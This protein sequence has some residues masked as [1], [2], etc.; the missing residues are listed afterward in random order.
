MRSVAWIGF[1]LA[2]CA[3]QPVDL[4]FT[5]DFDGVPFA[6]GTAY[7]GVGAGGCKRIR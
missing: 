7:E 4:A 5:A 3:P 2:A 6:C 1:V